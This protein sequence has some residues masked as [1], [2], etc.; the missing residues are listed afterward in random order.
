MPFTM[1]DK[2]C[3]HGR[4][5]IYQGGLCSDKNLQIACNPGTPMANQSRENH[6]RLCISAVRILR[7]TSGMVVRT[8]PSGG[9]PRTL[10]RPRPLLDPPQKLP[11]A[12]ENCT[13]FLLSSTYSIWAQAAWTISILGSLLFSSVSSCRNYPTLSTAVARYLFQQC[14]YRGPHNDTS[15]AQPDCLAI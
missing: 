11:S 13:I 10:T 9:W 8:G 14:M 5:A 7:N 1:V 2:G 15:F 3:N 12:L 6:P 4:T